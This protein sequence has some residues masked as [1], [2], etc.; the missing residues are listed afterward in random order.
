MKNEGFLKHLMENNQSLLEMRD[1]VRAEYE[2]I[3]GSLSNIDVLLDEIEN[4]INNSVFEIDA[5]EKDII[6]ADLR[7][8][9]KSETQEKE[10]S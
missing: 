9:Q 1:E 7:W 4:V 10:K 8:S 2:Q 6:M 3:E 5:K